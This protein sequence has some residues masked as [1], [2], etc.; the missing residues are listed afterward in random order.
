MQKESPSTPQHSQ[1][2][3][4]FSR[5]NVLGIA[6]STAA[7]LYESTATAEE[8][9]E[10][11]PDLQ[12]ASFQKEVLQAKGLIVVIFSAEWC[13]YCKEMEVSLLE[14]QKEFGQGIRILRMDTDNNTT[15]V[16]YRENPKNRSV[17]YCIFFW[18]GK[19]VDSSVGRL[20][21]ETIRIMIQRAIDTYGKK[22]AKES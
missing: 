2:E 6:L 15:D 20:P 22:P 8:K 19:G 12:D 11:L 14:L 7:A 3:H 10:K 17:P 21:K 1:S 5:R 16:P 13:R 4:R 9:K 18:E